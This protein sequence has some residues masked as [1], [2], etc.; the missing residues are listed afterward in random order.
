MCYSECDAF[1]SRCNSWQQQQKMHFAKSHIGRRQ[2]ALTTLMACFE[3][4][5]EK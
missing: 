2:V 4:R 3:M 1:V 5:K